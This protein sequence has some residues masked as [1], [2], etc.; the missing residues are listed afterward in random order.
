MLKG[1]SRR[2]GDQVLKDKDKMIRAMAKT[3]ILPSE[4]GQPGR[5]DT[6]FLAHLLAVK[7]GVNQA[8]LQEVGCPG[9]QGD[10][11]LKD[12]DKMIRDMAKTKKCRQFMV[13]M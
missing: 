2:P 1:V 4:P 7:N 12:K 3:K 8:S 13:W 9:D 11:I 5:L 6:C 10:Q